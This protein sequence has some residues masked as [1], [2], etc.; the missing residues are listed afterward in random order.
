M[1]RSDVQMS[2][3]VHEPEGDVFGA[4]SAQNHGR[5]AAAHLRICSVLEAYALLK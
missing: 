4:G 2:C 3:P 5:N 1:S